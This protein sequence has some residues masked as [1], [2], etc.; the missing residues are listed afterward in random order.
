MITREV[1]R[2]QA[3]CRR[4]FGEAEPRGKAK[5]QL[6]SAA[7]GARA[8]LHS[9][10]EPSR[11]TMSPTWLEDRIG[12]PWSTDDQQMNYQ[13]TPSPLTAITA[14]VSNALGQ[15]QIGTSLPNHRGAQTECHL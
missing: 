10:H 12:V 8:E 5:L 9:M 11:C 15:N 7:R 1:L 2:A 14:P 3:S 6:S 13:L 4:S